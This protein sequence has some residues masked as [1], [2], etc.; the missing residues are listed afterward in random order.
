MK[1]K[2]TVEN[3]PYYGGFNADIF[4]SQSSFGRFDD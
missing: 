1:R 2:K 4:E 3:F